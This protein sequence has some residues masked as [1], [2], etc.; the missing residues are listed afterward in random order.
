LAGSP[1]VTAESGRATG[2]PRPPEPQIHLK[3][4]IRR[5]RKHQ[6]LVLGI[7]LVTAITGVVWTFRQVPIFQGT[8]TVLI[9][10]EPPKVLNIQDVMP[11]G[12]AT[13]WDPNYYATQ[14]EII[15][16][17]SVLEKAIETA[18]LRERLPE[19]GTVS[20]PHRVLLAGLAVEPKRNTR[21]V[22]VRFEHPDPGTSALVANAIAQAYV[23]S[24]LDL[25]LR[26]A[27]DA[28]TWLAEEAAGLKAKVQASA[29]ALQNFRV[30]AG[31]LGLQ[32]QRQITAQ[33]IMDF[34]KAYLEAQAH[35]LSMEA[36]LRQ[37]QQIAA[38]KSG[39]L[40][41][42]TVA[43]SP[44]L[45]KLKADLADLEVEKSQALKTYKEKHPEVLKIEARV[46]QVNQKVDAE[47]QLMLRA[48]ETEFKVARA[49][50]DTLLNNVNQ[51]SRE[52]QTLSEKEI[53]Y[54][55]LQRESESNQQ[56]YDAV[57]KRLKETG[58]TGGLETNNVRVV[59]E[60][61]VPSAP[62]RPQKTQS[63]II[64]LVIGLC[65][66]VGVALG[67]EYFDA[68][69]RTPDDVERYL[70]RPVIGIVPRFSGGPR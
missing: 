31:I 23:K 38:D 4:H 43:D 52:G 45:Q 68:S 48:V 36:K 33:K 12:T 53:Q 9:E 35:R 57:L 70:G 61:A 5:L 44:I 2:L 51:L 58:V 21:L 47:I 55:A 56:L 14:Y 60:A 3:D 15:K 25:K 34:N 19:L 46:Q 49:R 37:L 62:V 13:P 41:I 8:A 24:N 20:E 40:T 30:K 69:L 11:L 59:E 50:E 26:G 65:L 16:S 66:A 27:K 29:V 67:I 42:F 28:V 32:E 22:F 63:L 54:L 64:T 39:A 10:P 1:D 17:R 6:W 7:F 18:K